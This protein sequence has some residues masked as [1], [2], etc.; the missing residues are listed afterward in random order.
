MRQG[1]MSSAG[2]RGDNGINEQNV[3][4]DPAGAGGK[5]GAFVPNDIPIADLADRNHPVSVGGQSGSSS[6][7]SGGHPRYMLVSGGGTGRP[8]RG[9]GVDGATGGAGGGSQQSGTSGSAPGGNGYFSA[10]NEYSISFGG[11]GSAGARGFD[12][13]N[14]GGNGGYGGGGGGGG[15]VVSRIDDR[16]PNV[17]SPRAGNGSG[18]NEV[19]GREPVMAVAV[20]RAD[21]ASVQVAAAVGAAVNARGNKASWKR[22]GRHR[23][24]RHHPGARIMSSGSGRERY[25]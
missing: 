24:D 4:V 6:F 13:D 3:S 12:N 19:A 11:A 21:M 22:C 20:V 10:F 1:V 2:S 8:G 25:L 17:N 16:A 18:G 9:N 23:G 5:A 14:Q 15:I 7:S